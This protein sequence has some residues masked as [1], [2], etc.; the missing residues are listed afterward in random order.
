MSICLHNIFARTELLKGYNCGSHL[1]VSS[2]MAF[3]ELICEKL[4]S[5]KTLRG[6]FVG[7]GQFFLYKNNKSKI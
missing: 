1:S 7:V 2:F 3:V 4:N 5:M 6:K